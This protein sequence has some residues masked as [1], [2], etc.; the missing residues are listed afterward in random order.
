MNQI[1]NHHPLINELLEQVNNERLGDIASAFE[2][3]SDDGKV[4]SIT[5]ALNQIFDRIIK[6]PSSEDC[7][8]KT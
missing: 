1:Q 8:N 4:I 5:E 2:G 7:A 6:E 3:A